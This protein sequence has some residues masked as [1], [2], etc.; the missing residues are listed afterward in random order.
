MGARVSGK[1]EKVFSLACQHCFFLDNRR[2][3]TDLRIQAISIVHLDV[4]A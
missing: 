2:I 1:S 3:R 4:R